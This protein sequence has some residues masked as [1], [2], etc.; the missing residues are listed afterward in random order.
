MWRI[1]GRL[2]STREILVAIALSSLTACCGSHASATAERAAPAGSDAAPL[3]HCGKQ[4][5]VAPHRAAMQR[6]CAACGADKVKFG[7]AD[8]AGMWVKM[9]CLPCGRKREGD[10][11]SLQ[12]MCAVCNTMGIFGPRGGVYGGILHCR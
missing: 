4:H 6:I 9:F 8:S 5:L 11:R 1:G 10:V 3:P 7:I 2:F 12:R